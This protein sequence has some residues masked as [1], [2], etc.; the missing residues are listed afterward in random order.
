[1]TLTGCTD[2]R[3]FFVGGSGVK[4]EP[5]TS[6]SRSGGG[7]TSGSAFKTEIGGGAFAGGVL[8]GSYDPV[9]GRYMPEPQYPD[10]D[11]DAPRVDIENINL[12]SDGDDDD[13][14][15][16]V[17]LTGVGRFN[18]G[19][20]KTLSN[21]GGL[22]PIRLDRKE[23]KD[24]VT[25]VNTE[26]TVKSA[27]KDDNDS[28]AM[29][30]DEGGSSRSVPQ[31]RSWTGTYGDDVPIKT[32]PGT[33]PEMRYSLEPTPSSPP[34][35]EFKVPGKVG[36][37]LEFG[38]EIT[39]PEPNSSGTEH[40]VKPHQA[41]NGKERMPVIQTE[42]DRAE[43]ERHVEDLDILRKE[44]VGLAPRLDPQNKGKDVEG[45]IGMEQEDTP[46]QKEDGR[47]YLFQFPPVLPKLFNEI[48]SSNPNDI[49]HDDD[50]EIMESLDL[51]KDKNAEVKSEEKV[52]EIKQE[53]L[54]ADEELKRKKGEALVV[55]EGSI[56]R[57]VV[58]ES[59]KVE[60]VWGGTNMKAS[61]GVE[62]SFYSGGAVVDSM[63]QWV[64]DEKGKDVPVMQGSR[65]MSLSM[66][67]IMGKFVATPDWTSTH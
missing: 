59:G 1:M 47:I 66:G 18:K 35:S 55:E 41:L 48:T 9:A 61:R 16:D 51:T 25:I 54:D 34:P 8:R 27:P 58:R 43:W 29:I 13:D 50:V 37:D 49:K 42:E 52:V 22:K 20:G 36:D 28:D 2:K 45:D 56:G 46:S 5:G 67:M 21:K 7:R 24:R 53:E 10:E 17:V 64:K 15:D 30:V 39:R 44:L 33:I 65:G 19:R 31:K 38:M 23:H 4:R 60:L 6:Y 26:S 3:G 62:A 11:D 40:R 14:D 32:E 63:D 12:A 57:L